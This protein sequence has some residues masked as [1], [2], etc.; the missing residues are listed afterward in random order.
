MDSWMGQADGLIEQRTTYL[1][2]HQLGAK[3][4]GASPQAPKIY[5]QPLP[6][7]VNPRLYHLKLRQRL[8]I[9]Q[10][11]QISGQPK[12][13]SKFAVSNIHLSLPC[14]GDQPLNQSYAARNSRQNVNIV[15]CQLWRSHRT[16]VLFNKVCCLRSIKVQLVLYNSHKYASAVRAVDGS[17]LLASLTRLAGKSFSLQKRAIVYP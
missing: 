4:I 8:N 10:Y 6:P 12:S 11:T 1:T 9:C 13:I 3:C 7:T 5:R 14:D 16:F 2:L 17:K 15:Q